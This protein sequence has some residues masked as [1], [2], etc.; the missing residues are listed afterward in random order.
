MSVFEEIAQH[1]GQKVKKDKRG[2]HI[3]VPGPGHSGADDSLIVRPKG[4]DDFTVHSFAGDT[5][6]GSKEWIRTEAGVG[7]PA[8]LRK[9]NGNGNG[10]GGG[11]KT[12]VAEYVYGTADSKPYLKVKKFVSDE[13]DKNG[14][15]KKSFYQ[16]H[17]DSKGWVAGKPAGPKIPFRLPELIASQ[18]SI[19]VFL[20]EGEKDALALA[21]IGLI[22]TAVSEGASAEWDPALTEHFAGRTVI[23]L[24]DADVAGRT[25][26]QNAAKALHGTADEIRIYELYPDGEKGEDVSDY[27]EERDPTGAQLMLSKIRKQT[28]EWTLADVKTEEDVVAD[29]LEG[30]DG[31][32]K[33]RRKK[34]LAKELGITAKELDKALADNS[35]MAQPPHWT[36][37]PWKEPVPTEELLNQLEALYIAHVI[38]PPHAVVAMVLWCLHTWAHDASSASAFLR[39]VSP[40]PECGKSKAMELLLYTTL[41]GIMASNI[42]PSSI[43]RYVD[44]HH[45]ALIFDE[46]E[47][48]TKR[49]D[50]RG[51]LDGSISRAGAYT[52]RNVGTDFEPKLFSTYGPKVIGGLGKMAA[53]ILSRCIT[54]HM[55]RKKKTEKITKL[56]GRDTDTFKAL[57]SQACRWRDDHIAKLMDAQPVLPD[58]LSDRGED[59][60]ESLF[61][62]AELAGPGW[63][64]KAHAAALALSG[65]RDVEDDDLGIQLL[66]VIRD[67]VE[68]TATTSSVDHLTSK[69][70]VARLLEDATGPW[71][72]Y[73]RDR[74]PIDE[75]QVAKLLK[76]FEI[77]P[78]QI[79]GSSRGYRLAWFDG[80]F[81]A[82]LGSTPD[83]PA[84]AA[85]ALKSKSDS[86]SRPATSEKLVAGEKSE[87]LNDAKPVAAVA[88]EKGVGAA[89]SPICDHCGSADGELLP[90]SIGGADIHLHR[91]C[92]DGWEAGR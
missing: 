9:K 7:K 23:I 46:A 29:E 41:R 30:L 4:D 72:A 16:E 73:G 79:K 64:A 86:R 90:C 91:D 65:R 19:P 17:W 69:A 61:A 5:W 44:R 88:G 31:I 49:E 57:R 51:I 56:R 3:R 55:T 11:I 84:T 10:N 15:P 59:C 48:Y 50:V 8:F 80:A 42:S 25:F 32:E 70:I 76:P 1:F 60:W 26:A 67:M 78:R 74:K 52:V 68:T 12:L 22:A 34:E 66:V 92:I 14:K 58:G 83:L 77:V 71:I 89:T 40:V 21:A 37:E 33:A 45:P 75:Q 53:T 47:T 36:V 24:P 54:I 28:S 35:A 2:P 6:E 81:G 85:T 18:I 27:L 43:F 63:V 87:N 82:Y 13:L 62:I 39:F 20:C 38:L